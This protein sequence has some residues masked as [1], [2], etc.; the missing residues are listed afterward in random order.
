MD[1]TGLG[2][3]PVFITETYFSGWVT[4]HENG[5]RE[6]RHDP[7]VRKLQPSGWREIVALLYSVPSLRMVKPPDSHG[8][9]PRLLEGFGGDTEGCTAY[10]SARLARAMPSCGMTGK[11]CPLKSTGLLCSVPARG[12]HANKSGSASSEALARSS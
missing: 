10:A 6:M 1:K 7:I 2:E 11:G 5:V 4:N 12:C 9:S 8:L 3:T